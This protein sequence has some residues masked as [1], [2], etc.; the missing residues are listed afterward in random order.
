MGNHHQLDYNM[1]I[2]TLARAKASLSS[3][4]QRLV[5]IE[6]PK[7]RKTDE[8]NKERAAWGQEEREERDG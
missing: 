3:H 5:V 7:E 8:A 2:N 4:A 1:S 6:G